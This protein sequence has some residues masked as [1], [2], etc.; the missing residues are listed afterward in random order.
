MLPEWKGKL[1]KDNAGRVMTDTDC[2][3]IFL[4]KVNGIV[5]VGMKTSLG[6]MI[7]AVVVH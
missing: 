4:Y 6:K 1:D 5:A 2:E 3:F 7:C